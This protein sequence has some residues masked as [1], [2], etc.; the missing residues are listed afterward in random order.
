MPVP[1]KAKEKPKSNILQ[2]IVKI[3]QCP[4]LCNSESVKIPKKKKAHKKHASDASELQNTNI[5]STG[6]T[7]NLHNVRQ[8]NR[9]SNTNVNMETQSVSLRQENENLMS[10]NIV[11][12]EKVAQ[13]SIGELGASSVSRRK[14][15]MKDKRKLDDQTNNMKLDIV[16]E[17]GVA[18]D[19]LTDHTDNK[20]EVCC[21][22]CVS[23][24][25]LKSL[26]HVY[27]VYII[28]FLYQ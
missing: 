15:K 25:E 10:E 28:N 24:N 26:K 9:P 3:S 18:E 11:C 8:E 23:I 1:G 17:D 5:Q 7:S 19:K 2:P 13:P 12:L 6:S 16:A 14:I 4:E 27:F 21:F 20:T 22:S